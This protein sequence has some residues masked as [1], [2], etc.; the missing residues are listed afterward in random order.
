MTRQTILLTAIITATFLFKPVQA[1][2]IVPGDFGASAVIE[3]FEGL[4]CGTNI[5]AVGNGAFLQP[6]FIEPYTFPSGVTLTEPAPNSS[7][8]GTLIGDF[9]LGDAS[10]TLLWNSIQSES[11]VAFGTAYMISGGDLS[12]GFVE[13]TFPTDMLRV[14]AYLSGGNDYAWLSVFDASGAL[15]ER[16]FVNTGGGGVDIWRT[17]FIGF[18]STAGIRKITI[19]GGPNMT[20]VVG[21]RHLLI[22]GLTFD[23]IPEP[24]TILLLGLGAVLLRKRR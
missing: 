13:F 17:N 16:D 19:E 8:E 3:S 22:D 5:P 11:D 23:P 24:T 12:C 2:Q 4:S 1:V 7:E 21:P 20:L 6:G 14:G 9:T 15:L 10:A 18:E